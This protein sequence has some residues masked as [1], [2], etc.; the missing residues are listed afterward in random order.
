MGGSRLYANIASTPFYIRNLSIRGFWCLLGV[1]EPIPCRYRGTTVVHRIIW[2][3]DLA[4]LHLELTM[5][6]WYCISIL[7]HGTVPISRLYFRILISGNTCLFSHLKRETDH[8]CINTFQT[9]DSAGWREIL[10]D[11]SWDW[12]HRQALHLPPYDCKSHIN[13][14][15]AGP[16]NQSSWCSLSRTFQKW[17]ILFYF[18]KECQQEFQIQFNQYLTTMTSPSPNPF[19]YNMDST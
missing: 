19:E 8:L 6:S 12:H 18:R 11:T 15:E 14:W 16:E 10:Q 3:S 13:M 4:V 7:Q 17:T 2:V 5:A 9:R 1:R